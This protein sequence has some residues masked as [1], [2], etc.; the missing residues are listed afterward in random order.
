VKYCSVLTTTPNIQEAR[1]IAGLLLFRRLAACIQIIP[2][3][4]SHYRWKGKKETSKEVL[5]I[6]KTKASLYKQLEKTIL[7]YHSYEVPE[8]ICLPITK[9]SRTYLNWI[10]QET[11]A[12]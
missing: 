2:A 5:L 1:K 6:I 9:G 12:V 3:I 7:R 8:I 11:A 4:E 10:S